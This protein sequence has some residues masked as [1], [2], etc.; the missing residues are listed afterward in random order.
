MRLNRSTDRQSSTILC[1]SGSSVAERAMGLGKGG[2]VG[3]SPCQA[4]GNWPGRCNVV[5]GGLGSGQHGEEC[6]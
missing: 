2:G 3:E 5:G 4:G 6:N 1:L